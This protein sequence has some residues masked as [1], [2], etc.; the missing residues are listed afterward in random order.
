[1]Q[2]KNKFH[3]LAIIAK[4]RGKRMNSM[5]VK[6]RHIDRNTINKYGT[7]TI[8]YHFKLIDTCKIFTIPVDKSKANL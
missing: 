2:F 5:C 4:V 8:Q 6:R 3:E 7:V 1:M